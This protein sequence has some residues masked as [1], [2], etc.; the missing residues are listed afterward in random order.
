MGRRP[1]LLVCLATLVALSCARGPGPSPAV[2]AE[3]AVRTTR[4]VF[5]GTFG[6]SNDA[7]EAREQ[8]RQ[9]LLRQG[10]FVVVDSEAEADAILMGSIS[11]GRAASGRLREYRPRG[12]LR[13]VQVRSRR[14]LWRHVYEVRDVDPPFEN[15]PPAQLIQQM[16]LQFSE[17]LHR[18]ADG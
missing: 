7:R 2:L 3:E 13:L 16:V 15:A 14:I 9:E 17:Q 12:D 6:V 8:M 4:T 10:R 5:L 11:L 1:A 18:F